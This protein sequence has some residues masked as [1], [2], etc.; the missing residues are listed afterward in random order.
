MENKNKKQ[1]LC[2]R[3]C[4]YASILSDTAILYNTLNGQFI[5]TTNINN[6]NLINRLHERKNLGV[7]L[8]DDG[9]LQNSDLHYFIED[10]VQKEI[11]SLIDY[12]ENQIKPIQLM[13]ILNIQRDIEKLKKETDRSLGEEI[14]FYL[15]ELNLFVNNQCGLQCNFCDKTFRQFNCCTSKN[16]KTQLKISDIKS[17]ANQIKIL[18][19][20]RIN[21]NGGN[22]FQYADLKQINDI[23]SDKEIHFWFHYSNFQP[24]IIDL[25][26]N[27]EVLINFP[28]KKEALSVCINILPKEKTT[29]HFIVSAV[30]DIKTAQNIISEF[31]IVKYEFHPFYNGMNKSFFEENVFLNLDDI[32]S[33]TISQRKIFCNQAL[34]SNFFGKL[35]IF[36]NGD[37]FANINTEKLGN[38]HNHSLLQLI[39]RELDINSI[40]RKTRT[41]KPCSECLYQYLCPPPSNYEIVI[42]K[43]NLCHVKP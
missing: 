1:W 26:D 25:D 41:E 38:I 20:L 43:P 34:N 16:E 42:G 12:Y 6:I 29:F 8:I 3:N 39:Y 17:I 24:D 30:E 27:F 31:P 40:W 13:P 33:E 2:L 10:A 18:S 28:F 35:N 21:I 4:V 22:I 5:I 23:F 9:D 15:T 19:A 32:T 36:P 14:I 7:I 37:V 11:F